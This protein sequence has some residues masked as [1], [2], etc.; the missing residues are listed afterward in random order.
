VKTSEV[1]ATESPLE[2]IKIGSTRHLASAAEADVADSTSRIPSIA[3]SWKRRVV[4]F[5]M[6]FLVDF[7]AQ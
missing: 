6:N 4:L 2:R 1:T 7:D 5:M 3:K